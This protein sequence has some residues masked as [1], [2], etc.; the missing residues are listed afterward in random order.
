MMTGSGAL[1]NDN[2]RVLRRGHTKEI[3]E[4]KLAMPPRGI[5]LAK[6]RA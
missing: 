2:E 1:F 5:W 3:Y 4:M 6:I